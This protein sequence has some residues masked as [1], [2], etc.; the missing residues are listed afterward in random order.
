MQQ[1]IFS[2]FAFISVELANSFWPRKL[3]AAPIRVF[4]YEALFK[5]LVEHFIPRLQVVDEKEAVRFLTAPDEERIQGAVWFMQLRH[6]RKVVQ[7]N[8]HLIQF[9]HLQ[10]LRR[11]RD[12]ALLLD[13]APQRRLVPILP[14]GVIDGNGRTEDVDSLEDAPALLQNQ[15]DQSHGFAEFAGAEE[16]AGARDQG[17]HGVRGL[18]AAVFRHRKE[19]D[20]SHPFVSLAKFKAAGPEARLCVTTLSR[21][22]L[23]YSSA[24]RVFSGINQR[25]GMQ[26]NY[27]GSKAWLAPHMDRLLGDVAVLHSPFFGSGKLEYYLAARRAWRQRLR[28]RRKPAPLLLEAR[29]GLPALLA[30]PGG[31]QGGQALLLRAPPA[32]RSERPRRAPGRLRVRPA[33]QQLL[34][35][36]GLLRTAE[37]AGTEQR[38]ASAAATLQR[39]HQCIYADP[40]Y[41]FPGRSMNYYGTRGG[42]DLVFHTELRDALFASGLPFV[43][44]VNDVPEARELYSGADSITSLCSGKNSSKPELLVVHRGNSAVSTGMV[45]A[46]LLPQQD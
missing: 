43:V 40:P 1:E 2:H 21:S 19:L 29:P 16:D 20:L 28:A 31:A 24:L 22:A 12:L 39:A 5:A 33:A 7:D 9:L 8:Q 27:F 36:V 41:I 45:E 37:A 10:L 32:G 35:K 3:S 11:L 44:S 15:A 30:A 6:V 34:G 42:H 46:I 26:L 17:H 13:D 18:F 38:A 25:A 23:L 4:N 14:V